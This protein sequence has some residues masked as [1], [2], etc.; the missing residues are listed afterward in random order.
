MKRKHAVTLVAL[1]LVIPVT[2]IG[3]KK[4]EQAKE[5]TAPTQQAAAPAQPAA[6]PQPAGN[7]V[8]EF[9]FEDGTQKWLGRKG[10]KLTQDTAQKQS[11]NAA[12]KVA[13]TSAKAEWDFAESPKFNLVPGKHYKF[14]GWVKVDE[15]K[16]QAAKTNCWLKVGIYKDNQWIKNV[17]NNNYDLT[18]KGE[19]QQLSAEFD[20]PADSNLTANFT[21]DKRPQEKAVTATI[22]V[23]DVKIEQ[24]N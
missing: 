22:Y 15:F 19:W 23:D 20:A 8:A 13:G 11:G 6:A 14:S 12:L 9:N 4:A 7:V 16:S 10:T 5:E 18:R 24:T 3:C 1:A 21:V 2:L 17:V